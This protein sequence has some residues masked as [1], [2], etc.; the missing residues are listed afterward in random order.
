MS[1]ETQ[2]TTPDGG[3]PF[4]TLDADI[5]QIKNE[6]TQP[7]TPRD[8][9]GK[10]VS[11]QGE[12]PAEEATEEPAETSPAD[13]QSRYKEL[14]N[15]SAAEK[16]HVQAWFSQHFPTKN[17]WEEFQQWSESEA[18]VAEAAQQSQQ[19]AA[20]PDAAEEDDIFETVESLKKWKS[21]TEKR[22]GDL[23]SYKEAEED[24]FW[25]GKTAKEADAL[26]KKYPA[27]STKEGREM[28][29]SITLANMDRGMTMDEAA[30]QIQALA[31]AGAIG[32]PQA[33]V[34][35]PP[36]AIRKGKSRP[37]PQG[38][39]SD[40]REASWYSGTMNAFD[41]IAKDTKKEFG[42]SH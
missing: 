2:A 14:E 35:T 11:Q 12:E 9:S 26:A 28:M 40:E 25:L 33:K 34:E 15:A 38:E 21:D 3:D 36:T 19:S 20:L 30:K 37:S 31:G 41:M 6:A 7:E 29:F 4:A 39:E 16:Q 24:K 42:I 32:N 27:V 18:G 5:N 17:R 13:W 23:S 10:F 22:L 8:E 1:D